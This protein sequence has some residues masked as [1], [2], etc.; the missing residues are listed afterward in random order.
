MAS[1]P[2]VVLRKDEMVVHPSDLNEDLVWQVFRRSCNPR[3][4]LNHWAM[5]LMM[6][7]LLLLLRLI[8]CCCCR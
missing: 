3:N 4:R 8:R 2:D 1:V 6:L 5:L 7:L